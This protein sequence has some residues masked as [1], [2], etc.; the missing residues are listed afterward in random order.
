MKVKIN[1]Y[2]II[3]LLLLICCIG[4]C[5]NMGMI[6][7]ASTLVIVLIT[8]FCKLEVVFE[9]LFISLPFFN[10]LNLKVGQTSLY[11]L[12]V[13][14]FI[15]KYVIKHRGFEIT[16]KFLLIVLIVLITIPNLIAVTSTYLSWILLLIPLIL[17]YKEDFLK[18]NFNNIIY[19]YAL[20]M[21]ISSVFVLYM[22]MNNVYVYIPAYVWN[23]G[24][25]VI[26][27]SGLIGDSNVYSQSLLIIIS[28]LLF[29]IF[30]N[31]NSNH[32]IAIVYIL[33]LGCFGILTYSKM[34]LIALVL[35]AFISLLY[36][37]VSNMKYKTINLKLMLFSIILIV[38]C[39]FGIS[40]IINNTDN[41]VIS[42]YLTR[43]SVNDLLT[44][45]TTVYSHFITILNNN[46]LYYFVGMGLENYI[47]PFSISSEE[48]VKY[49]HNLYVECISL[50]GVPI[51]VLV[52]TFIGSKIVQNLKVNH[53][54]I[55]IMPMLI[56]L[57]TGFTLHGN[58]EFS[59]F[60]NL[61]LI[62]QCLNYRGG[63]NEKKCGK[64]K[65]LI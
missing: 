60:F 36:F 51:T 12:L 54:V 52:L 64:E 39:V 14:V 55:I 56:L 29:D 24:D 42:S 47:T 10:A 20:S 25:T 48:V 63:I 57:L 32:K 41:E 37:Y 43:F 18:K 44:G 50:Y 27:F 35:I 1:L 26:R 30:F 22:Q 46:P 58:L 38:G 3:Y 19:K 53:S 6:S 15:L 61:I 40:Y 9:I 62:L 28:L 13:I 8:L 59:F 17:S 21:I 4:H 23:D 34:N 65:L 11:Y 5:I 45:R 49:A 16:K 2:V 7:F 31:K 33:L